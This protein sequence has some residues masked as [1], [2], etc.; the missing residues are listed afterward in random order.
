MNQAHATMRRIGLQLIEEKRQAIL[1][2]AVV[3]PEVAGDRTRGRDLLSVLST[4]VD[5]FGVE[6]S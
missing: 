2:E 3:E 4:P 1:N 6:S 5:C